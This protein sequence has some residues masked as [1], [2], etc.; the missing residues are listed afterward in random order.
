[1]PNGFIGLPPVYFPI[2]Y[3]ANG[4]S[5][6][7]PQ[8]Q[9]QEAVV[10]EAEK[11]FCVKGHLWILSCDSTGCREVQQAFYDTDG[12]AE[13]VQL[14]SELKGH[15]WEAARHPHANYVLQAV[16]TTMRPFDLQFV[17]DEILGAD[18]EREKRVVKLARHKFG[19]RVLQRIL[20]H[21]STEQVSGIVHPLILSASKCSQH[22]YAHYVMQHICEFG[23]PEQQLQISMTFSSDPQI[24]AENTFAAGVAAKL[25]EHSE[26]DC[27]VSLAMVL[28]ADERVVPRMSSS[29][30]GHA[31]VKAMLAILEG[32]DRELACSQIQTELNSP[33]TRFGRRSLAL[34]GAAKSS[35]S[36]RGMAEVI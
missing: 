16:I 35:E 25:F 18:D 6:A 19:C 20:E 30:K 27:S 10:K 9:Q 15:V 17:I 36:E 4:E 14:A 23:S 26:K 21:C 11:K 24:L 7:P 13:R 31:A 29:R 3:R 32:E 33:K 28:L 22:I 34:A 2:P 12:D 1:M 5:A 8:L